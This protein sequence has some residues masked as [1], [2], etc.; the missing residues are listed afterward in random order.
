MNQ[1]TITV[2]AG[3]RRAKRACYMPTS[4]S[5]QHTLPT[6]QKHALY[7]SPRTVQERGEQVADVDE[8]A[9][10]RRLV[11]LTCHYR[12]GRGGAALLAATARLAAAHD[13]GGRQDAVRSQHL[14]GAVGNAGGRMEGR[15]HQHWRHDECCSFG[16]VRW[17]PDR[18]AASFRATTCYVSSSSPTGQRAGTHSQR[19]IH[20]G[21]VLD[22]DNMLGPQHR[23]Q[24]CV[25]Q[26][27][28]GMGLR[29]KAGWKGRWGQHAVGTTA[30]QRAA[31]GRPPGRTAVPR[32][33]LRSFCTACC[34]CRAAARAVG[35]GP[36]RQHPPTGGS[37]RRACML[38]MLLSPRQWSL[39]FQR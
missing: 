20:A 8:P 9:N 16:Q 26:E 13:H 12:G 2:R 32:A 5:K 4:A 3:R 14:P 36:R 24:I 17:H 1:P 30:L 25:G 19:L 39:W 28:P 21:A 38:G 6:P 18:T 35:T 11:R 29:L 22:R 7:C 10:L 23:H 15:K 34:C 31:P 33:R 27:R 37:R